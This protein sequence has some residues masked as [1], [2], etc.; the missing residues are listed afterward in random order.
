MVSVSL[1]GGTSAR[2]LKDPPGGPY[3]F[4]EKVL[5]V[6]P[7]MPPVDQAV[8]PMSI[9]IGEQMDHIERRLADGR[10]LR[11]RGDSHS[12]AQGGRL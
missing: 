11:F 9:T 1:N 4:A 3:N 10:V 7:A 2:F 12:R 6:K 8:A 5:A